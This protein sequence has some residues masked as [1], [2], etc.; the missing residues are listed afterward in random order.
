MSD[1]ISV[2]ARIAAAF[3]TMQLILSNHDIYNVDAFDG[4]E[5]KTAEYAL[6]LKL[7]RLTEKCAICDA[8]NMLFDSME[9][10]ATPLKIKAAYL[11]YRDLDAMNDEQ[12][13]SHGF[14]RREV[15]D[16]LWDC[17]DLFMKSE[18]SVG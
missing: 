17:E 2:P 14:S 16:G 12:L 13:S 18:D 10:A 8:E 3:E 11:F 7:K 6:H 5:M 15:L 9:E 1:I 4:D